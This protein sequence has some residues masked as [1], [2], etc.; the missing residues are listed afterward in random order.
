MRVHYRDEGPAEGEVVVLSG[1]IGSNLDMWQPQIDP[2]ISAGFRVVRYDHRG[3]GQSPVPAA[4]ASLA[5]LGGD[6]I[7]L[8]DTL[9]VDRAHFIGL[10]LGGMVGMWLA[11]HQPDRIGKLG[12]C[13]T[14][15]Q[16]GTHE[17]WAQRAEKARTAGMTAI[18]D[19]SV[20][21][22]FTG[23]WRTAHPELAREYHAM[24]ATT[25]AAGYA[26][27]CAAIGSMD[28]GDGLSTIT[29]PTL[30]IAGAD[31]PATSVE[32]HAR[33]IAE[34]IPRARLAVLEQASHLANVEQ[35]ERFTAL[36]VDFLQEAQS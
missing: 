26:A 17:M 27:C 15:A 22:W 32:E 31:D 4:D 24:T 14:S 1:S 23:Q 29:A 20:V 30:V 9:G 33:P 19:D 12:L 5:D 7:E 28:L 16:L 21:R 25:P 3:H 34:A 13:C 11:I 10:S 36:T 8:L 35:P 18:A 6:V 2:L